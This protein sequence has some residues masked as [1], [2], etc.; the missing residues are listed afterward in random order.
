MERSTKDPGEM[1]LEM[2]TGKCFIIKI[3]GIK[4]SG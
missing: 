2:E 1:E 4:E 3:I